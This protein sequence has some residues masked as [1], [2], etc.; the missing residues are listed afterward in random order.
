MEVIC[1]KPFDICF[2]LSCI[3]SRAR[4]PDPKVGETFN[5]IDETTRDGLKY[6][7]LKEREGVWYLAEH[8]ANVPDEILRQQLRAAQ[9]VASTSTNG[10]TILR[11]IE[12]IQEY[13]SKLKQYGAE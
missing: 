6:F 3:I 8:F 13:K 11:A 9:I 10:I 2:C 4:H 1:V 12:Q 7:E 5:V